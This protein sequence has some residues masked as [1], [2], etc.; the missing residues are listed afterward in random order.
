M[1]ENSFVVRGWEAPEEVVLTRP[2]IHTK[3]LQPEDLGVLAAL[4]LQNP[5]E[6]STIKALAAEL[7]E[8]GWKMSL[9]RFEKVLARLTA[10]GHV[11]RE[12]VFNPATKRPE[13]VSR[14][15]RNPANN[16]SYLDRGS[17]EASQVSGGIGENPIPPVERASELGENPVSPGQSEIGENPSSG[18]TRVRKPDVP[19]GQGRD[20]GKPDSGFHPPH[21]PE[22]VDTSSP[23]P[24][25]SASRPEEE[26]AV[27]HSLEKLL[28]AA[29]FLKK[30]PSP[31]TAGRSSAKRLAP[32]L[33]EALE[34]QGWPPLA[35]LTPRYGALLVRELTKNPEG[36]NDYSRILPKR[37]EDLPL[38]EVVAGA[39]IPS[40]AGPARGLPEEIAEVRQQERPPLSPDTIAFLESMR[41]PKL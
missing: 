13:W 40:Q 36:I 38:Y 24:H 14:V 28:D 20:R 3:G 34:E 39:P 23:S 37:V 32:K 22:E 6:P 17:L 35:K 4:L 26:V 19:A 11:Y 5:N 1:S 30:L 25:D 18:K 16:Q 41:K 27:V 10:A 2:L 31:W 12:S 29:M 15:Y 8:L 7:R 9:D 21:P 33:L